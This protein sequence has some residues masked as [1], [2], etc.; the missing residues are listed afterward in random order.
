M[1]FQAA[2][3]DLDGTLVDSVADLAEAVNHELS[4]M[5]Y[6]THPLNAFYH[7]VGN[8]VKK[9]CERALPETADSDAAET[10]LERFYAY[11]EVHCLDNTRPYSGMLETVRAIKENGMKLAVAS[12]KPQKFTERIVRHFFGLE[13]FD[14]ILGSNGVRPRKPEPDIV[15]ELLSCLAVSAEGT[16]L[17]GDSD[18]DMLTAANAGI[19]SI[20]CTWGFRGREELQAAGAHYLADSPAALTEILCD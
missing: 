5:G 6:P 7:F 3:F 19:T 8:G 17:I 2:I 16:V 1:K 4:Q 10:L 12:N 14:Y 9:L 11:Y 13:T 18:V 20:G 15:A